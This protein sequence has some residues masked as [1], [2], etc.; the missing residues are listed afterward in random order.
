MK[1]ASSYLVMGQFTI[2]AYQTVMDI[3]QNIL[4]L[5]YLW[6]YYFQSN[7]LWHFLLTEDIAIPLHSSLFNVSSVSTVKQVC[8][9]ANVAR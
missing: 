8:M 4:F 1:H 3:A 5:K 9:S 7:N 6:H 2:V